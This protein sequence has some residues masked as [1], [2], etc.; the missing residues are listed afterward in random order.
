MSSKILPLILLLA[1]IGAQAEEDWH[2]ETISYEVKEQTKIFWGFGSDKGKKTAT[3]VSIEIPKGVFFEGCVKVLDN[4][5]DGKWCDNEEPIVTGVLEKNGKK[6]RVVI[7][8]GGGQYDLKKFPEM[9]TV[10]G[11]SKS[12]KHVALSRPY[13]QWAILT[14]GKYPSDSH[15]AGYFSIRSID[16]T[17]GRFKYFKDALKSSNGC[18]LNGN[19]NEISADSDEHIAPNEWLFEGVFDEIM[20]SMKC[21]EVPWSYVEKWNKDQEVKRKKASSKK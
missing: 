9:K 10:D 4:F 8:L 12:Y 18:T 11:R 7:G 5:L 6:R 2:P 21:E 3:Y 20:R 13:S 19:F 17:K 15:E 1:S 14:H 16:Q